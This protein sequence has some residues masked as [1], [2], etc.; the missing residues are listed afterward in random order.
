MIDAGLLRPG[1]LVLLSGGRDSV[2]LVHAA[3]AAV[4]GV[5]AL[6]VDHG[7][8]DVAAERALCESLCAGLGVPLHVHRAGA[9]RGNVQAWGREVRY[10]A[11]AALTDGDVAVGHTA[12]DQV[13][14]VLYRLAASPGRRALR[15]MSGIAPLPG[16]PSR[17]LVRPL[18]GVT[19]E[20]TREYCRSHGLVYV[21]DPSNSSRAYARNRVRHDLLEA[22]RSIHPAAEANVLRTLE[23][24]RDEAEVLDAVADAVRTDDLAELRALPPALARLL[25]GPRAQDI[26]ALEAGAL[27]LG[28]G[29]RAVIEH[30]R[31]RIT[32]D[33]PPSAPAPATLPIPGETAFGTGRIAASVMLGPERGPDLTLADGD[34]DAAALAPALEVRAWRDGDRMRPLGLGGSK[35]LQDLF[36]DR[37]VPREARRA[38]PVVVSDG[39]I[40][41]VPGVATGEA[42]RVS[43]ATR[44]RVRLCWHP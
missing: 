3:A 1:V 13:E 16:E 9:P 7:L 24:L 29:E 28:G 37:K 17:R 39:E 31:V 44:E 25:L 27:D 18:L 5:R 38:V 12:S 42:F 26:L 30:G 20:W 34:V 19:R 40:A 2:C 43:A 21:D 15:G 36:T 11:A 32:R 41:W 10:R 4:E 14:T 8:R 23:V 33:P 22:L 35:S 6:F